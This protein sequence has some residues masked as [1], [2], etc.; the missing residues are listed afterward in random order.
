MRRRPDFRSLRRAQRRFGIRATILSVG[1]FLLYVLLSSFVPA[2][3]NQPLFGRLTRTDPGSRAVRRHGRDRVVLRPAHA[4]PGRSARPRPEV[5][6]VRDR[7]PLRP[8][9]AA[10]AGGRAAAPA[11]AMCGDHLS[12]AACW[13][14]PGWSR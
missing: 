4:H 5:P 1:G 6:A 9:G 2:V 13:A 3:M 11:L 8:F 14:A 7:E 10:S 12:A